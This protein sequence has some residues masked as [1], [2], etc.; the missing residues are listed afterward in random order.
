MNQER[1]DELAKA[2]ATNDLSQL[3]FGRSRFLRLVGLGLLG[4]L[5]ATIVAPRE[6]E[7]QQTPTT[8]SPCHGSAECSPSCSGAQPDYT[9]SPGTCYTE[10]GYVGNC[11]YGEAPR[12]DRC[13]D[14]WV[15]CDYLVDGTTDPCFCSTYVTT[16]C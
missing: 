10:G 11:W 14:I 9:P 7:S 4:S 6:A 3:R 15:C 16:Q 1:F 2:L 5:A 8:T 13:T 12:S